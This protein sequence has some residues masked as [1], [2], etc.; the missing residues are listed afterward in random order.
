MKGIHRGIVFLL[1]IAVFTAGCMPFGSGKRVRGKVVLEGTDLGIW[2]TVSLGNHSLTTNDDG[3]FTVDLPAGTYQF[4]VSNLLGTFEG[5]VTLRE[6]GTARLEIPTSV[7]PDWSVRGF[8]SFLI[9]EEA[10]SVRTTRWPRYSEL[11]VWVEPLEA[12]PDL[13]PEVRDRAL[14]SFRKWE[15]HLDGIITFRFVSDPKNADIQLWWDPDDPD[16]R[17]E[18]S[19]CRYRVDDGKWYMSDAKIVITSYTANEGHY[20]HEIGHCLGLG[21]AF[22]IEEMIDWA[23]DYVMGTGWELTERDVIWMK[24]LYSIPVGTPRLPEK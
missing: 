11:K 15:E 20:E 9:V 10:G 14:K 21:H 19:Y 5:V 13:T 16:A 7:I 2:S 22:E 8:N 6:S 23:H 4:Q 3:T 1:L 12:N 18:F 17:G 24:L